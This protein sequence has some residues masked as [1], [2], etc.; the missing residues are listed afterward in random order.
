MAR[1][2]TETAPERAGVHLIMGEVEV[3]RDGPDEIPTEIACCE[4]Y[5]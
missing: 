5:G 1:R 4:T 3:E 2:G